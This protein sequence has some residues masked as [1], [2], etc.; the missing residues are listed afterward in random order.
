MEGGREG[1]HDE[2]RKGG[3]RRKGLRVVSVCGCGGYVLCRD[4]E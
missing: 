3:G 4:V 2:R 1:G